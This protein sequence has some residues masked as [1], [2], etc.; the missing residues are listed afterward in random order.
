MDKKLPDTINNTEELNFDNVK[1]VLATDLS[2][3]DQVS[4]FLDAISISPDEIQTIYESTC[5]RLQQVFQ[6]NFNSCKTYRF[7]STV[8]G[9]GFKNCDLDVYLDIGNV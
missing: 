8:S 3:N 4:K 5:T 7:G 1:A 6:K 2:F 9:L